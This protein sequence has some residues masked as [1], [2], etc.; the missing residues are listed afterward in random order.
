MYPD[1]DG[2]ARA[3]GVDAADAPTIAPLPDQVDL[4]TK[5]DV[6]GAIISQDEPLYTFIPG[7]AELKYKAPVINASPS[8]SNVGSDVLEPKYLSSKLS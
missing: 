8:L 7:S 2:A 4:L 1:V 5:F 6:S 3:T